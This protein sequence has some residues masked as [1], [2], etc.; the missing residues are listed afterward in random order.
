MLRIRGIS[1]IILAVAA[2]CAACSGRSVNVLQ[3]TP[4]RQSGSNQTSHL[5]KHANIMS[6]YPSPHP[7]KA[8]TARVRTP[9]AAPT[10]STVD[11]C[12]Q[13]Q[14]IIQGQQGSLGWSAP[15]YCDES[16][17]PVIQYYALNF[18]SS[19][20]ATF[21]PNPVSTCP[22]DTTET[23]T[24][25][26]SAS[27]G[28]Y[29][30]NVP[31]LPVGDPPSG[32]TAW[33]I[34]VMCSVNLDT[35]PKLQIVENGTV[36]SS[37]TPTPTAV[38]G[39]QQAVTMRWDASSGKNG[40]YTLSSP[41][42]TT[43]TQA[44]AGYNLQQ[45]QVAPTPEALTSSDKQATTL[46]FYLTNPSGSTTLTAKATL[47]S[48]KE[49][50]N[51]KVTTAFHLI[52]PSLTMTSV[53]NPVQV[54]LYPFPN[55]SPSATPDY[56]EA[57]S[58]G[59]PIAGSA[60]ITW[61]FNASNPAGQTVSGI[62]NVVQ[63]ITSTQTSTPTGCEGVSTSGVELDNQL[64]YAS[65][66]SVPGTWMSDDSPAS[67]LVSPCT[68]FTRSDSFVDYLMFQPSASASIWTP[69]GKLK[70]SWSGTASFSNGTW[71]LTKKSWTHS[72][73][74]SASFG[75]PAWSGIFTNSN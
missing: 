41:A 3:P 58:I 75:F 30:E 43:P 62:M 65:D 47:K 39:E 60:G 49:T 8:N 51:V 34:R 73:S 11:V 9:Q 55:P 70:W 28:V 37:P 18:P 56:E 66:A 31:A 64:F 21:S 10:D 67:Q 44:I 72:P 36:I 45:Q 1:L 57:L 71:S 27:P 19:I 4:T 53:T 29:T 26:A 52:A 20:S 7:G 74:G 15:A 54:A 38:V 13:Q 35:C 68:S 69:I 61:T 48:S 22:Y 59:Q 46:S 25:D 16:P 2:W 24:V 42:W 32:G 23:I 17:P 40:P 33:T 6:A 12:D 63:T 50:A 5:A 14:C